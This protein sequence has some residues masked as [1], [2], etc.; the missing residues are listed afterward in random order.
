L[1]MANALQNQRTNTV[2]AKAK[3]WAYLIAVGVPPFGLFFAAK[4]YMSD[5]DD[6]KEVG[7]M[8]II[9]TVISV[10]MFFAFGKLFFSSAGVTPQQIEQ[11][12]PS[13]IQQLYQ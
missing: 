2:S 8:C 9:L 10:V 3:H 5:E 13:D 12:K 4:Y 7:R 6:A 1:L 11:I